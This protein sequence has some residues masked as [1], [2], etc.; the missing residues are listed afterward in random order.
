MAKTA[1]HCATASSSPA[2]NSFQ[3]CT[4]TGALPDHMSRGAGGV[5]FATVHASTAASCSCMHATPTL[6]YSRCAAMRE[7]SVSFSSAFVAY[8]IGASP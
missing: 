5:P 1:V 8:S 3:L 6:W 4:H 2:R 7:G